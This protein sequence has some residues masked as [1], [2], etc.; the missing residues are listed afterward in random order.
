M[1]KLKLILLSVLSIG[2]LTI[3]AIKTYSLFETNAT[4]T[5]SA[6]LAKWEISVNN[7]NIT[8]LTQTNRTFNL[9]QINWS[10][11]N[12]VKS[13]K[14]APGSTGTVDVVIT[15]TNTEVSFI[16]DITIDLTN[17]HNEE[18]QIYQVIEQSGDTITR[19]GPNT[20][21]GIAYLSDIEND[22]EYDIEITFIWNNSATNDESDYNLGSRTNED[23]NIPITV[24]VRQYVT[25][26]VIEEYQEPVNEDPGNV[27]PG[28]GSQGNENTGNE[29]QNP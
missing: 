28:N 8:G 9:G 13:G 10:N 25:G 15:P 26:D 2:I 7:S 17:L 20:Y 23:I 11:Q 12:H 27:E 4:G 5:A 16:Y 29:E 18:F 14:G 19:T 24:R 1:T 3:T 21:T 6:R 22:K